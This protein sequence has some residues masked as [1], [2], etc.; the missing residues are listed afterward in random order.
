LAASELPM[1]VENKEEAN[2]VHDA[3]AVVEKRER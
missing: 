3:R 1:E 2:T